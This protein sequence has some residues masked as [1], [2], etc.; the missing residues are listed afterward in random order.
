[1]QLPD[2]RHPTGR[3]QSL[4]SNM[5]ALPGSGLTAPG[6]SK[7]LNAHREVSDELT[8]DDGIVDLVRGGYDVATRIGALTDSNFLAQ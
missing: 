2:S 8:L 1:M 7:Y 6:G 5:P 3:R 4:R